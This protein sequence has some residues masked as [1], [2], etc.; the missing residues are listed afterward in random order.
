MK[1]ILIIL[2]IALICVCIPFSAFASEE[3]TTQ[4]ASQPRL[5]VTEYKVENGYI[6][7]SNKTNLEIK[8][9]NYSNKKALY[10]IKL[11]IVDESGEIKTNGMPTTYI[12]SIYAGSSYVW[13][14]PLTASATAQIGEHKLTVT[15]EY[16]DKYYTPYTATDTIN[17]TVKQTVGLD[18]DGIILPAKVIQGDTITMEVN[19]MNTGKTDIRNVKLT[20]DIE[21][22]ETGG[23]LFIGEIPA[24]ESGS[25][26]ANLRVF[27][28]KAGEITGTVALSYEDALG[29]SYSKEINVSSVIEEKTEIA[30]TEKETEEKKNPL[31]W[32]FLITGLIVGATAGFAIP[33]AIHNSKQRK[34]DE[35]RL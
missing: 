24:G 29:Q 12:E 2:T 8:F 15:A 20:F 31:W 6:T 23:V 14:I 18:Y 34:E 32:V 11:S 9:K 1:K 21:S 26:N 35:L 28:D 30:E 27:S 7:P 16:E 3:E 4:D 33:T 13:K 17:V 10:N 5:M 22:M 19:L 25:G